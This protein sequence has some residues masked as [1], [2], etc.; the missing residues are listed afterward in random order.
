M[1]L[2]SVASSAR[3][4]NV[5]FDHIWLRD[6]ISSQENHMLLRT[7]DP[8]INLQWFCRGLLRGPCFVLSTSLE[9]ATQGDKNICIHLLFLAMPISAPIG[10]SIDG[11]TSAIAECGRQ[12][13]WERSL[14]LLN[15]LERRRLPCSVKTFGAAMG[16]CATATEW[17]RALCL[18]EEYDVRRLAPD[19]AAYNAAIQA[20]GKVAS[21]NQ[22]LS[23]FEE[24]ETVEEPNCI[25]YNT[26]LF[27]CVEG[28][29]WERALGFLKDFKT[30]SFDPTFQTWSIEIQLRALLASSSLWEAG[31]Q[32]IAENFLETSR[33]TAEI[34]DRDKVQVE[35]AFC[36]FLG[37]TSAAW[38]LGLSLLVELKDRRMTPTQEMYREAM[39][40]QMSGLEGLE[41]PFDLGPEDLLG[42]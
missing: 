30:K 31:L 35:H 33:I 13:R 9:H 41:A 37:T 15:K 32:I 12:L 5:R 8:Q 34:S 25:N 39:S 17:E 21:T 20:C 28:G 1:C 42:G 38:Q 6:G 14:I 22:A 26:I 18:L 4:L 3:T 36:A 19:R 24:L 16:A 27:A 29:A 2:H 11:Y 10:V 23:L 7:Q 40:G